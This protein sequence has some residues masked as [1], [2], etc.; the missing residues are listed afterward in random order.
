[1]LH[2]VRLVFTREGPLS[3]VFMLNCLTKGCKFNRFFSSFV[4][5]IELN[6]WCSMRLVYRDGGLDAVPLFEVN[7][8]C[9][10]MLFTELAVLFFIWSHQSSS[11]YSYYCWY[12][13]CCGLDI[14]LDMRPGIRYCPRERLLM[15]MTW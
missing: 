6:S 14:R 13:N 3:S 9:I 4:H 8:Q 5:R 1:M 7:M 11:Y 12:Y 15:A 10:S 2:G